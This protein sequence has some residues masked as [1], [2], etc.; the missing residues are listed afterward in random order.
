VFKIATSNKSLLAMVGRS[1][2]LS[3]IIRGNLLLVP[4]TEDHGLADR[5][6]SSVWVDRVAMS[7]ETVAGRFRDLDG[8]LIDLSQHL[9]NPTV[10]DVAVSSGIT[11]LEL[12]DRYRAHGLSPRFYISDKFARCLCVQ[13]GPVARIYDSYGTLLQGRV[14]ALLADPQASW[15][16]PLSR[17]LFLLLDRTTPC[18]SAQHFTEILLYNR[19][20][21]EALTAGAM[22][23]LDYDV[24]SSSVD[25]KFDVVRCMNT[26]TRKYFSPDRIAQALANLGRS[27]KPS[28][29]LLVGR[30]LPDGRNDA[31][32][33]RV[34][35]E[36]FVPERVVN[37]GADIHDIVT[38]L[39][40]RRD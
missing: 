34:L 13:R 30:T 17:L 26:I 14:G 10:H 12:L 27:L 22:T 28:A 29:L 19:G 33:F 15:R 31:T 1:T 2:F 6:V 25:I 4:L 18:L 8:I 7:K 36:R 21:R 37:Q 3:R 23:H 38:S 11:S 35:D 9:L 5:I 20:I 24:F 39:A 40:I 32:F 16:F